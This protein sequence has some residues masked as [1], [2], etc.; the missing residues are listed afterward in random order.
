MPD[1]KE[2]IRTWTGFWNCLWSA[3]LFKIVSLY[4]Q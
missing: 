1:M 4:S 3:D 2:Y